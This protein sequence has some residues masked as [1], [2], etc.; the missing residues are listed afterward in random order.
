MLQRHLPPSNQLPANSAQL[1]AYINDA[2]DSRLASLIALPTRFPRGGQPPLSSSSAQSCPRP[3]SSLHVSDHSHTLLSST[4]S[5]NVPSLALSSSSCPRA[6]PSG[7][8]TSAAGAGSH[9]HT[10]IPLRTSRPTST[11]TSS[12]ISTR[13]ASEVR[14]N[15]ILEE[16]DD[17]TLISDHLTPL[18]C[19]FF[20]LACRA[21]F[22]HFDDWMK[23]SLDH[24]G[25]DVLPPRR[26]IC[27]ICDVTFDGPDGLRSWEAR[28]KH[29]ELVHYRHGD[30]VSMARPDFAL[31]AY[32][33]D[34]NLITADR[35]TELCRPTESEAPDF[36]EEQLRARP[37][38]EGSDVRR[39]R[40]RGMWRV[41]QDGGQRERQRVDRQR[42]A[43][44]NY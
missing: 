37:E 25:A 13:R 44:F 8:G 9:T 4:D 14:G 32:L 7:G 15:L 36:I 17:G 29:I 23:H 22:V 1:Q 10:T 16:A 35:Y 33:R 5:R 20:F 30:D 3:S 26:N 2:S 27:C 34:N 24:F 31:F 41:V 43:R 11:S 39:Q 28:M 40:E 6:F 12:T 19:P 18:Q 42:F 38:P 21:T